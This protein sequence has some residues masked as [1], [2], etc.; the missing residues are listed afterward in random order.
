V[1]VDPKLRRADHEE[2]Q[3]RRDH[4]GEHAQKKRPA[5]ADHRVDE[6]EQ[7]QRGCAESG[8]L[9]LQA[10]R[11]SLAQ[12]TAEALLGLKQQLAKLSPRERREVSAFLIRLRHDTTEWKKKTAATIKAMQAGQQT[13]VTELRKRLRDAR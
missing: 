5:V 2:D 9:T 6:G 8:T 13:S 11:L 10:V 3:R 12:M 4:G 1:S 7:Q